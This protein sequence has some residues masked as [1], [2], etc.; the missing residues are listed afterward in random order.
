MF[1]N[2][3]NNRKQCVVIN[4]NENTLFQD[5]VRGLPQGSIPGPLLFILY[6]NGLKNV[7]NA[8]DSIIFIGNTN[9]FIADKNVDTIFTKTNLQL[10]K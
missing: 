9:L 10:Q 6:I 5:I 8:Q 7:S 4:D 1:E 2:Y 3:L